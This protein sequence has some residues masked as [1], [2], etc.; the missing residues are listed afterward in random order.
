MARNPK[1]EAIVERCEEVRGVL[2]LSKS[3]FA[4]DFAM[5][6]QTYNNFI[7]AQGSKPNAELIMGVVE[8][9]GVDAHWLLFGTGA[10]WR[11]GH[12]PLPTTERARTL[13]EAIAN[14][15]R[16]VQRLEAAAGTQATE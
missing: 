6:P 1:L 13:Q 16:R 12:A 9:H 4:K 5:K 14:L 11:D 2:G 3:A 10:M 8:A 15:E 7:G